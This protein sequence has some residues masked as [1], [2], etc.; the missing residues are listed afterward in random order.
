MKNNTKT[1]L[2]QAWQDKQ[3]ELLLLKNQL[4]KIC[5]VTSH[6]SFYYILD[7]TKQL[8]DEQKKEIA[9]LFNKSVKQLFPKPKKILIE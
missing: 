8:T 6:Q 4:M 1:P 3:N 2:Q 9:L 5:R 7:G